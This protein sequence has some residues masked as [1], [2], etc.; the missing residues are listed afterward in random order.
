MRDL[1]ATDGL[2]PAG[3]AAAAAGA[4][5]AVRRLIVSALVPPAA[6][7]GLLAGILVGVAVGVAAGVV[8]AV[9]A[10]VAAAAAA[11]QVVRARGERT[12]PADLGGVP[13]DP[14]RHARLINLTEGLCAGAGVRLP[15]LR[16]LDVPSLNLAVVGRRRAPSTVVVT[17]G[18]LGQ[19]TRVELEGALALA[20]VAL[21]RGDAVIATVAAAV[22][23]TPSR[24]GRLDEAILDAAAV[25]LTRYPPG[26]RS[27]LEACARHGTAV[28]GVPRRASRLWIL[29]P[30]PDTAPDRQRRPLR[31]RIDALSEL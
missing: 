5:R 23:R 16:V 28:P 26:L 31:E 7:V 14:A 24:S 9:V 13:A 17:A 1:A 6:A 18:L 30:F 22:G 25:R 27:A 21:R 12:L 3:D 20:V 4:A 11:A 10:A 2:S 15:E 29:D 19:L 8:A